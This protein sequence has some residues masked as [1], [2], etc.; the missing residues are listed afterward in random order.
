MPKKKL[1][2]VNNVPTQR[3]SKRTSIPFS[4]TFRHKLQNGYKFTDLKRE[5]YKEF[6]AF[7]DKVCGMSF[8]D[9][10]ILYRRKSDE[11]DT[12]NDE[13]VI[14]YWVGGAFRIHGTIESGQF[15]VLRLDPGHK[16]HKL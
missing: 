12:Y 2:Q 11:H 7:L 6:Q 16:V 10:D 14:H 3:L 5:D 1:T 8:N 13:Q 4:I 15:I 9:V